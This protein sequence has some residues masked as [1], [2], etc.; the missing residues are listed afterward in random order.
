MIAYDRKSFFCILLFLL[1]YRKEEFRLFLNYKK[2]GWKA[3]DFFRQEEVCRFFNAHLIK[4][5]Y[6][7]LC[8]IHWML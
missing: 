7:T 1:F 3:A 6:S 5:G 2:K 8:R 4:G